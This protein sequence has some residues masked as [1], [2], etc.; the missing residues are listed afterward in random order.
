MSLFSEGAGSYPDTILIAALVTFTVLSTTFNPLVFLY[1]FRKPNSIPKFLFEILT[2]LDFLTCLFFSAHHVPILAV[3]GAPKCYPDERYGALCEGWGS[4]QVVPSTAQR[5]TT[6][7]GSILYMSPSCVTAVLTVCRFRQLKFPFRPIKV[8]FC[9]IFMVV[10]LGYSGFI[11]YWSVSDS[12]AFYYHPIGGVMT[13]ALFTGTDAE[14]RNVVQVFCLQNW[15]LIICQISSIL[16]SLGTI[17]VILNEHK[18]APEPDLYRQ[19]NNSRRRTAK[20]LITNV[21]SLIMTAA[22]VKILTMLLT[23]TKSQKLSMYV[24]YVTF[25]VCVLL[26]TFL[27]CLNPIVFLLLT[28][29]ARRQTSYCSNFAPRFRYRGSRT[30]RLNSNSDPRTERIQLNL[31]TSV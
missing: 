27:S 14:V 20:I 4:L 7:L 17:V 18:I 19:Q 31:I 5:V 3:K 2:V 23:T 24:F 1:N 25:A 13:K 8:R 15:P 6:L 26:P 10:Y 30:N 28:P 21:G 12:T 29:K 11:Q 9:V 16:A 22:L